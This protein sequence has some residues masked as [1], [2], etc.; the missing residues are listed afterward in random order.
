[1]GD[2]FGGESGGEAAEFGGNLKG[3]GDVGQ[4]EFFGRGVDEDVEGV[5]SGAQE[6]FGGFPFGILK[7]KGALGAEFGLIAA[8]VGFDG[9]PGTK[10]FGVVGTDTFAPVEAVRPHFD[11]VEID[12]GEFGDFSEGTVLADVEVAQ[13]SFE[14]FVGF[15]GSRLEGKLRVEG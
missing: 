8:G 11:G 4:T 14:G 3:A 10:K 13:E 2:L 7:L 1:M 9:K 5:L 12:A 15:V 6:F